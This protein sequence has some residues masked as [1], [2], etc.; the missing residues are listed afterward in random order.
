MYRHSTI[1]K[2]FPCDLGFPYSSFSSSNRR[3][4]PSSRKLA[5]ATK[6]APVISFGGPRNEITPHLRRVQLQK[7]ATLRE[8]FGKRL[9]QIR[10]QMR[11]SQEK[12]AEDIGISVDF[13]SLIERGRNSPSFDRLE[14]MA[15]ALQ[16]PVAFLFTFD[17]MKK[18]NSS[19]RKKN[20]I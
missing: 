13:L 17:E 14:R 19:P 9:K 3:K 10:S 8:E 11:R 4:H 16:K 2:P 1:L 18:P 6:W 7:L 5:T 15:K 12:F 20:R